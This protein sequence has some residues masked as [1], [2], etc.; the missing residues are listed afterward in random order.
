MRILPASGL[1]TLSLVLAALSAT[2][3]TAQEPIAQE[4]TAQGPAPNM[5][6]P[7]P[8]E[9]EADIIVT[10]RSQRGRVDAPQPPLLDLGEEDI[11]AYGAST[12]A[13]LLEALAPQTTSGRGRGGGRPVVLVNGTRIS[14]FRELSS[15][16][17]E[18][19]ERVEV[20]P[21]EVAQ[22]YG[23]SADQ[24]VVNLILKPNYQSRS[25]EVEYGQPF[26]GGYSTKEAEATYV[27][28]NGPSRLNLNLGWSDTTLLTEAERGI[29]QAV[30]SAPVAPGDPSPAE[31]RSLVGDAAGV[32][33]TANLT[34]RLTED[35]TTLSLNA[36]YRRDDVLRLQGLD[37]VTLIDPAGARLLRVFGAE[38]PIVVD[39]R[40]STYAFGSGL[41]GTAG[42]W[43]LAATAD[44]SRVDSDSRTDRRADT[45]ALLAAAAAGTRAL[46][47]TLPVLP[48][49]GFDRAETTIDS[50]STSLT[51]IGRPLL[52]PAG[53]LGLTLDAGYGW[54]R[55]DSRDTRN[56]AG[57]TQLTRGDANAGIN[58]S[59]PLTSVRE[60]VLAGVGDLT[61]SFTAGVDHLS[62]F[63][64]L[65]EW[66]TGLNWSPTRTLNVTASYF[67]RDSA[68]SLG[69]LGNPEIATPNVPVFDLATGETVLATIITG[70]NPLLPAQSQSDWKLG[71]TWELPFLERSNLSLEYIDNHSDD[72]AAGFPLL[73][74]TTEAAFPE[75]VIR[76]EVGRLVSIDQRPV[77][78]AQ[79]DSRRLQ[80]GINLSGPFG[81]ARPG[82]EAGGGAPGG[83][84]QGGRGRFAEQAAA[85]AAP[86]SPGAAPAPGGAP[87][88]TPAASMGAGRS[89]DPE[90]F[91]ALRERLCT[92]DAQGALT[93]LELTPEMLA[94]L[95]EPM[96]QR[97]RGA[98]GQL[99]PQRVAELREQF[100]SAEGPR[101]G[102]R[103]GQGA[104]AEIDPQAL[105]ALRQRLC[106]R[107]EAGNLMVLESTPEMI[108]ELPEAM[109]Q[110]LRGRDGQFDPERLARLREGLCSAQ[111][112]EASA[113]PA[114][115]GQP[116]PPAAGRG[117]GGRGPGAGAFLPGRGGDGRGRWFANLNY[118][119]EIENEVL[120]SPGG[121]LLDLL[122]GD[123]LSG[124]GQPRHSARLEGGMFYRGWGLRV[125]GRYIGDSRVE[126]S[127]L[128]GSSDLFFDDYATL[129]LR[130]FLDL[131][132]RE[133]W[134]AAVPL[135][136]KT[137]V[138]LSVSNVFD[139]RQRVTDSAGEVPLRYQPFLIDPV[140]RFLEVE[141]RKLF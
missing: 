41:N 64:T 109:Q 136:E 8:G 73:T 97:L 57:T 125:S 25:V 21:E 49:A 32:E 82:A 34:T 12:I 86:V 17:P 93:Q 42:D 52:L 101:Q 14:S 87:G 59:V 95:P 127:D 1:L 35:G 129:D 6:A 78:F 68:P 130:L 5:G 92:R 62:D 51:A 36:T 15:Y 33:A 20:F 45:S 40:T 112:V 26:D 4:A 88:A 70:G 60:D 140:G 115:D 63:G 118:S 119:Y 121:P 48:D 111:G 7:A 74:P 139:A 128:P 120:V 132:R 91:R 46:D 9:P 18:A 72:V 110:R 103:L 24:R 134:I 116:A 56:A 126:G 71:V 138:S 122:S 31:F 75:R 61:L 85:P 29:V 27:R 38:N 19:I 43:R 16:P 83:R 89:F 102:P 47:A 58:L 39:S 53:E 123:A 67:S 79:Q 13:E 114:T 10:G 2:P 3:T 117:P 81:A 11:A 100:C 90:R 55:I 37:S 54:T 77:T 84:G 28:I 113:S 99:D 106:G 23:Y 105:V 96:Q 66:S 65:T 76:D 104:M 107:D 94:Q 141:L 44:I 22:R 131:D 30:G 108:S 80:V 137:R 69:Q 133:S 124:G 98:D 135:L 50:A